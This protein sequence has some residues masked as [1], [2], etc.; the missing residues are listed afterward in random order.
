MEADAGGILHRVA[1]GGQRGIYAALSDA[2]DTK[3]AGG[4]RVFHQDRLDLGAVVSGGKHIAVKA[5]VIKPLPF[6]IGHLLA[7]C[8]AHALE[9][10]PLNLPLA[11]AGIYGPAHVVGSGHLEHLDHAGLQ[12]HLHLC[13]LG[14]EGQAVGRHLAGGG[15]ELLALQVGGGSHLRQGGHGLAAAGN[16]AVVQL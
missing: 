7:D 15:H 2:D 12:V 3:H 14:V 9:H 8:I 11:Q 10:A 6:H 13:G 5:L 4:V 16:Y 1:N